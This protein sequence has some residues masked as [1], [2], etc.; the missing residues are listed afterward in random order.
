MFPPGIL[1]CLF[2]K[3]VVKCLAAKIETRFGTIGHNSTSA[4]SASASNRDRTRRRSSARG[5]SPA[6]LGRNIAGRTPCSSAPRARV[7]KDDRAVVCKLAADLIFPTIWP[8]YYY[9]GA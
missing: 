2:Y 7:A 1:G 3:L 4:Q 9:G 5:K 8:I 6:R